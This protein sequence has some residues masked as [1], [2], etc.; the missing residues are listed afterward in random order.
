LIVV[1]LILTYWAVHGILAIWFLLLLLSR[2]P[3]SA[4]AFG[5]LDLITALFDLTPHGPGDSFEWDVMPRIGYV[6]L[7]AL[8]IVVALAGRRAGRPKGAPPPRAPE[9]SAPASNESQ[10]RVEGS[11]A[12][13]AYC[14][15]EVRTTARNWV[16]C[17]DCLARHHE[18]CWRVWARCA[19]C[20]ATT[21]LSFASGQAGAPRPL[22]KHTTSAVLTLLVGGLVAFLLFEA[23]RAPR[24]RR[25]TLEKSESGVSRRLVLE[26]ASSTTP[27][28]RL[29]RV[30]EAV[31][32][33]E[34]AT[35]TSGDP[36]GLDWAWSELESDTDLDT[37]HGPVRPHPDRSLA[38]ALEARLSDPEAVTQVSKLIHI[39]MRVRVLAAAA[40]VT[41][42]SPAALDAI[43][44]AATEPEGALLA[45]T[46]SGR[47]PT[48]N[49][50]WARETVLQKLANRSD[51]GPERAEALIATSPHPSPRLLVLLVAHGDA[52]TDAVIRAL[53]SLA[54]DDE[55]ADVLDELAHTRGKSRDDAEKIADACAR[56]W[57][58]KAK[59]ALEVLLDGGQVS[60]DAVIHA[61]TSSL[62]DQDYDTVLCALARARGR[63]DAGKIAAALEH[64]RKRW[65]STPYAYSARTVL[66]QLAD[67]GASTETV[68]ASVASVDSANTVEWM[69]IELRREVLRELVRP[70]RLEEM[71][72]AEADRI[73]TAVREGDGQILL[74]LVGHASRPAIEKGAA[75]LSGQD[76][77]SV[78]DALAQRS[79]R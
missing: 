33:L 9:E 43:V 28:I 17:A 12:R 4:I 7:A 25:L 21:C 78:L 8:V 19:T 54:S 50:A 26:E 69:N 79:A 55:R 60:T 74:A 18:A 66:V 35:G 67:N 23:F 77:F 63:T 49:G 39:Q 36:A 76:R 37:G 51:L 32:P 48:G 75:A 45:P 38:Q 29:L 56:S 30:V 3:R 24:P 20:R 62:F 34:D 61:A 15:D 13:C 59:S 44:R 16:A 6:E 31:P 72:E 64:V 46:P 11:V 73:A 41:S 22:G 70:Q 40:S 58:T 53:P 47:K 71:Q 14:H 2:G 42:L 52:S 65:G 57:S 1:L 27:G 68:L 5:V 10:A